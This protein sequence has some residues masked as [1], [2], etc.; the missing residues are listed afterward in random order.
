MRVIVNYDAVAFSSYPHLHGDELVQCMFGTA[1]IP[2]SPITDLWWNW[3]ENNHAVYD[4]KVLPPSPWYRAAEF[5]KAGFDIVK[6]TNAATRARGLGCWA[7]VRINGSDTDGAP[8]VDLPPLKRQHPEWTMVGPRVRERRSGPLWNFE[9]KGVRDHKLDA[10]KELL[11]LYEWDGIEIDYARVCPVLPPGEAWVKRDYITD[12]MVQVKSLG[13]PVAARVP[14]TLA[15]CHFDGLDVE[16][17]PVDIFTRGCRSFDVEKLDVA[18]EQYPV[19]DEVHSSDGYHHAPL[20][21]YRGVITNWMHQGF[22]GIQT[23]NFNDSNPHADQ[24]PGWDEGEWLAKRFCHHCAIYKDIGDGLKGPKTYVIQRRGGGRASA[25]SYPW[26]WDEP[27]RQYCNTNPEAQLPSY[28]PHRLLHMY[29]AEPGDGVLKVTFGDAPGPTKARVNNV[30]LDP[31]S[32]ALDESWASW[33]VPA[34]AL[35]E[36]DNIIDIHAYTSIE[37]VELT[38]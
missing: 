7:S 15:G 33:E 30:T 34:G 24:V 11:D 18:V 8:G 25:R 12:F 31:E 32:W 13:K 38:I 23:F 20:S 19:L 21:V 10:I 6:E 29:V 35:A 17:W 27:R 14:E 26:A 37:K 2:N 28:P 1:D 4:S 22:D 16:A 9:H 5:K 36:G 3:G